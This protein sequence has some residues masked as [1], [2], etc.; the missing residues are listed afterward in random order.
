MAREVQ[1]GAESSAWPDCCARGVLS[2]HDDVCREEGWEEE[3]TRRE[4]IECP[5]VVIQRARAMFLFDV[6]YP[7]WPGEYRAEQRVVHGQIALLVAS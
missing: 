1:S 7:A 6:A 2:S 4:K 5:D 3:Q